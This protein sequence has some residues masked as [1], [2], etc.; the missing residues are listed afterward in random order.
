LFRFAADY[1][2]ATVLRLFGDSTATILADASS[3][4]NGLFGQIFRRL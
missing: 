1:D 2:G 4:H 3:C